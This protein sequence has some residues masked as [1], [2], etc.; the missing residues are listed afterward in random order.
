MSYPMS[1]FDF[2]TCHDLSSLSNIRAVQELHG[3]PKNVQTLVICKSQV[4]VREH[5]AAVAAVASVMDLFEAAPPMPDDVYADYVAA[6]ERVNQLRRQWTTKTDLLYH[7][8]HLTDHYGVVP[9]ASQSHHREATALRQ[10]LDERK[11]TLQAL[12]QR[13]AERFHA[14]IA[15]ATSL[16]DA[17]MKVAL[18]KLDAST[19]QVFDAI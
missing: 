17:T 2:G 12:N 8:D 4:I 5:E 15:F 3:L 18:A 1:K 7:T 13:R 14:L 11:R 10:C 9:P 19:V 6:C 16:R